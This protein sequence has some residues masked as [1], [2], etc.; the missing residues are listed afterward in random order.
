MMILL[1]GCQPVFPLELVVENKLNTMLPVYWLCIQCILH[2][3]GVIIQPVC[4]CG[5]L[6]CTW[7]INIV[8]AILNLMFI[9]D[10]STCV[11]TMSYGLLT[12]CCDP[13]LLQL[14]PHNALFWQSPTYPQPPP[15][16]PH[17]HPTTTTT[18]VTTNTTNLPA[19][20]SPGERPPLRHNHG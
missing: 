7:V 8:K 11:L 6:T 18:T 2:N 17:P 3:G 14:T 12:C 9:N 1:Y 20:P 19:Y 10:L 13:A 5:L 15:P 4:C 16:H